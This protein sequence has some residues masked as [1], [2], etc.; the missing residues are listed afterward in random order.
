[1][2]HAD[3]GEHNG[4]YGGGEGLELT[5]METLACINTPPAS[6]VEVYLLVE[7]ARSAWTSR[8]CATFSVP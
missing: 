1:M 6:V 2:R 5:R 8:K 4:V 7:G 3:S